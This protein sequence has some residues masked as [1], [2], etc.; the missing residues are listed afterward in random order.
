MSANLLD[1]LSPLADKASRINGVVVGI[2]TC[3]RDPDGMAR[4]RVKF[5]WLSGSDESW[6]ARLAAPMAGGDRG[7]YF[8]PEVDDEVLVAFEHGDIRFPYVL[9]GLWNG[10]QAPPIKNDDGKNNL[11]V[12][13]SR[14]G[15]VIRLD[16]SD[17]SEKIEIIDKTGD[18]SIVIDSSSNKISIKSD[19]D[20]LLESQSKVAVKGPTI[21]I[22]AS[23]ELKLKGS[24]VNIN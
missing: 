3:N 4:V 12:I 1:L 17:G 18:N 10:K 20:I 22:E 8:L 24:I 23:G 5:P 15:H 9:G 19:G 7:V 13:H 21:E 14:S 6:W 11:R 16:D 2:V